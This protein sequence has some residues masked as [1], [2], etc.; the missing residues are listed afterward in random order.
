MCEYGE[1]YP[2]RT[3]ELMYPWEFR[4]SPAG[5]TT[6]ANA[7]ITE[8]RHRLKVMVDDAPSEKAKQ[9]AEAMYCNFVSC[10]EQN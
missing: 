3:F 10:L 6:I 5:C 8:L 4:M 7:P 2:D 1:K 9:L